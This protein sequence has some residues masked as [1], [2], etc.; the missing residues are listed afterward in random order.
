M[1]PR[2][3]EQY[4]KEAVPALMKQFGYKNRLQVP[5]LERIVLNMGLGKGTADPK[6]VETG[7]SEQAKIA[8]Q[9][10]VVTRAKK[11]ISNFKLRKGLQIGAMVTLRQRNMYEFMDR[12]CNVALPRVRDFKGVS[13]KSFDTR[14][15]YTLGIRE[16]IIFPEIDFD[17]VDKVLGM[18]VTFVT[19]A[20]TSEE[21]KALLGYLGMPFRKN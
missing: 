19:T 16:H 9:K 10:P 3:R 5:R 1:N 15:N 7:A 11:A 8:G 14:G 6:I 21:A 13:P 17:K 12:L 20:R 2:I 18:N 4:D